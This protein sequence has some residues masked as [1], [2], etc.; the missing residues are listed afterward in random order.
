M[1]RKT[2]VIFLALAASIGISWLRMPSNPVPGFYHFG[3]ET[4]AFMLK[5]MLLRVS[6]DLL[7]GFI[8]GAFLTSRQILTGTLVSALAVVLAVFINDPNV[9]SEQPISAFL[10]SVIIRA[11]IYGSAGSALGLFVL[12]SNNSFKADASGAA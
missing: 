2:I 7:P 5:D 10:L 12:G 1:L 8:I 11:G 9:W 4:G 6:G 3:P